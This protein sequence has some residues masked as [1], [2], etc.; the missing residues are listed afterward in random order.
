MRRMVPHSG[1]LSSPQTTKCTLNLEAS[2]RRA[3]VG[4]K[5]VYI[6][7]AEQVSGVLGVES[8]S[9][10]DSPPHQHRLQNEMWGFL[11]YCYGGVR[12]CGY[13]VHG[14]NTFSLN[15]ISSIGDLRRK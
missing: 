6:Y 10:N 13:G 9:N 15:G 4:V 7:K 2:A 12:Q 3:P 11:F 1:Y 8:S 14:G 5:Q